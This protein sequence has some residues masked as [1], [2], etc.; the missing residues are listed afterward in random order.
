MAEAWVFPM[1]MLCLY[2][3][4]TYMRPSEPFIT[5]YL[6]GPDK[7]LTHKEVFNE[8]FPVWTYSH[9]A[10]LLPVFLV[11]DFLRYKPVIILQ[12]ASLIVTYL[13]LMYAQGLMATQFMEFFYGVSTATEIAYY[14]YIYS[15]VDSAQY[16]RGTSYCRSITLVGYTVGSVTGQVLVSLAQV[17]LFYLNAITLTSVTLAFVTSW[18]LP[19]PNKS[20]FFH[21]AHG[22]VDKKE[23]TGKAAKLPPRVL[24]R[25]A[26][27]DP[28]SKVPLNAEE[29]PP[30]AQKVKAGQAGGGGGGFLEVLRMLSLDL[31]QCY[32]S[33][34][35]LCW[36]VWWALST[37]GYFQLIN[38][39][40]ALWE[41]VLPSQ[42]S[43][44]YNGCVE[45]ISTLLDLGLSPH[46]TA[47]LAGGGP[48]IGH[49]SSTV[50]TGFSFSQDSRT[51]VMLLDDFTS[52]GAHHSH[53]S[54]WSHK[55]R[56]SVTFE[57]QVEQHSKENSNS[58][59]LQV[60]AEI[61]K[62][63]DSYA[64]CLA[65][66]IET[67]AKLFLFG[68]EKSI[69][70]SV[71]PV[72]ASLGSTQRGPRYL[73]GQRLRLESIDEGIVH[74]GNEEEEDIEEICA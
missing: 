50:D 73:N 55:R 2:G 52:D 70:F 8:I 40:Q 41:E 10:L 45:A 56:S 44:I 19:M 49:S 25:A 67:D 57:D 9:L 60:T 32:S 12:G 18:F 59:T 69:L 13:M 15:V 17:P 20:L 53:H 47:M 27:E 36:S 63:L 30:A 34:P 35:L 46:L 26:L 65:K 48:L 23:L 38:Y 4:F 62:S 42:D 6:V 22:C 74:D 24:S 16:Q 51:D 33:W 58:S 3:F 64:S 7:N 43:D 37:C 39:A 1:F 54:G 66:A 28:E 31:L 61:H 68:D 71:R 14:S 29:S 21:Q 5:A 11:T 72:P